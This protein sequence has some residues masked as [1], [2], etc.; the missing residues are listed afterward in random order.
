[1]F[2]WSQFS[3]Q[4]EEALLRHPGSNPVRR[5]APCREL[6]FTSSIWE[7]HQTDVSI[8]LRNFELFLTPENNVTRFM[9]NIQTKSQ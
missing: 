1:M 2:N 4:L 8:Y 9:H 5:Q 7:N 6:V 3:L